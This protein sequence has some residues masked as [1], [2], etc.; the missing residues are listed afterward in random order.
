[1]IDV[2]DPTVAATLAHPVV[3]CVDAFL[4]ERD[5]S[6]E[7]IANTIFP[8]TP[9]ER[10]GHPGF[11]EKFH[12]RVLPKVHNNKRWSGYYFEHMTKLPM[13]S[14][15]NLDQLSREIERMRDNTSL[16]KHEIAL[17]DPER[18]VT[19]SPYGG[20]CLSFLSFHLLPGTPRTVL[21]TESLLHRKAA[22]QLDRSGTPNGAHGVV[23]EPKAAAG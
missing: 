7:T 3:A 2:A 15:G 11:I 1:M 19:G 10:Y 21:L 5:K 6:V 14:G 22:R 17:F 9:Y 20:K 8:Q 12:T 16:N 13:V 23:G 18:D 4:T